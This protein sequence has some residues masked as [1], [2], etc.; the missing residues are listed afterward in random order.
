MD[1][2]VS[3]ISPYTSQAF[4]LGQ[5]LYLKTRYPVLGL[6]PRDFTTRL[7]PVVKAE[8]ARGWPQC[9]STVKE[10]FPCAI[11][12]QIAV[13]ALL[14]L[15][16]LDGQ[17]GV[18]DPTVDL[19]RQ[20][21]TWT[22]SDPLSLFVLGPWLKRFPQEWPRL[23]GLSGDPVIWVRRAPLVCTAY[24]NGGVTGGPV[25]TVIEAIRPIHREQPQPR[26]TDT[27][28]LV[29]R[30]LHEPDPIVQKAMSWA[31]RELGAVS[32]KEVMAFVE[33]HK[34]LLPRPVMTEALKKIR[35]R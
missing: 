24:V 26:P 35:R 22:I 12:H 19:L 34:S 4:A 8:Y 9:L 33:E 14:A 18:F 5:Q 21:D 23:V 30:Y 3:A 20:V 17:P 28:A 13:C 10:W 2:L 27:L 11:E 15:F 6:N 1:A 16:A 31:L 32:P 25:A 7:A 29:A